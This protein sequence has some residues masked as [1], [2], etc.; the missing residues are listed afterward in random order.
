MKHNKNNSAVDRKILSDIMGNTSIL[1][2]YEKYRIVFQ[3]KT[4]RR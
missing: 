4:V 1:S 3:L 2:L